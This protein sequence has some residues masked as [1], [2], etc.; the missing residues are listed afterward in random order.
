ML[1][2]YSESIIV[3]WEKYERIV[4]HKDRLQTLKY[5]EY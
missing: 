4:V 3:V 1:F 5:D 2:F